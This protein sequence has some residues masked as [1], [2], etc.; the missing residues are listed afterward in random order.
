MS[1]RY[2]VLAITGGDQTCADRPG[3]FC[4]YV[5]VTRMGSCYHCRLFSALRPGKH[6]LEQL[7]EKAGWLQRHP[8]CR[9]AEAATTA[10]PRKKPRRPA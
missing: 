1:R 5:V 10:T 8:A 4:P 9:R 2:V 3:H 7:Q 6:G